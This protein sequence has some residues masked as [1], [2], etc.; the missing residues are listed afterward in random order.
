MSQFLSNISCNGDPVNLE[1]F[2]VDEEMD[3]EL[4]EE[5]LQ[6]ICDP[7]MSIFIFQPRF[8]GSITISHLA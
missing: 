8:I 1:F 5:F 2:G 7:L 3:E 4:D 6:V